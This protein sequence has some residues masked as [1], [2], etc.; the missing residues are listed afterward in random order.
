MP[1]LA[2]SS[3]EEGLGRVPGASSGGFS[4]VEDHI[5]H[6]VSRINRRCGLDEPVFTEFLREESLP[7]EEVGGGATTKQDRAGRAW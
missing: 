1:W 6:L 2:S 7:V 3:L 5:L 4:K